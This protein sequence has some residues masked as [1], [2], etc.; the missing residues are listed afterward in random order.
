MDADAVWRT[1]DEQRADLA[2]LFEEL[3]DDQWKTPSLCQGWRVREVGAHLTLAQMRPATAL[4]ALIH[5]RG[6][7]DRMIHETAVAQAEL[8]PD[9]YAPLLRTMVGSR[10]KAPG[11]T[12]LEPLIDVL[13]H[14][15]DIALPLN[16]SRAIPLE[17][18]AAACTRVWRMGFP[19]RARRRLSG[20]RLVAVDRRW[21][22]GEG[23]V[24]EGPL[25]SLLLVLTGRPAGV[26]RLDG[27]GTALLAER[28]RAQLPDSKP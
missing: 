18:A 21:S 24:V 22:V 19:F 26:A 3:T 20:I 15:Q 7:F 28:L 16:L 12:H 9:R 6:G 17:A 8:P 1:I 2:D 13:V 27:P 14:G 5:A 23:A 4:R 11:V 10:R 25:A